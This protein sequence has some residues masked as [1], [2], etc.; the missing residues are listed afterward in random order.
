MRKVFTIPGKYAMLIVNKKGKEVDKMR[1]YT[2]NLVLA[3]VFSALTAIGAFIKLPLG[4]MSLTLQFLVTAL[5]GVVLG[6]KWGAA[7]QAVYV[8]LG[9][10]GVPVFTQGGG[11]GYLFQ[12]SFGFLL[13]LAPAAA[14]IGLLT[15]GN[16]H[17]K[18]VIP[19]CVAGL[20]VLY[21]IGLPYMGLILTVYLGK[22]MTVPA[23]IW[24]G[25]CVYLP[26]DALKIAVTAFLSPALCRA[27][28]R[29]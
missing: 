26:G 17:P 8:V 20:A 18:C 12:P 24:S 6:P 4:A 22:S 11:L 1:S 28:Q 19:A 15:Q 10:A 21:L 7:S 29:A 9:L 27:V 25:M 16:S 3:A 23:L 5:A 14:V 13:G 2:Q